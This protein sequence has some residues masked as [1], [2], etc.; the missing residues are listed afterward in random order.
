MEA[1]AGTAADFAV[2]VS[3]TAATTAVTG[4]PTATAAIMA[5]MKAAVISFA[6]A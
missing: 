5:T 1:E 4:T 6:A 3:A 2:V